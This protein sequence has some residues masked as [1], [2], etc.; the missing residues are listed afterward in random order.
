MSHRTL[1]TLCLIVTFALTAACG[2]SER[3]AS[4]TGYDGPTQIEGE[5]PDRGG[6]SGFASALAQLM[7]T[8][9]RND[10]SVHTL[11][12]ECAFE[13][14]G[15]NSV[16]QCLEDNIDELVFED[17]LTECFAQAMTDLPTPPASLQRV[18]NDALVASNTFDTC[19]AAIDTSSCPDDLETIGAAIETCEA[20]RDTALED[21]EPAEGDQDWIDQ[22]EQAVEEAGCFSFGPGDGG[23]PTP[24]STGGDVTPDGDL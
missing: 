10:N 23:N 1:A 9:A 7:G 15:Y 4:A 2:S 19:I 3:R 11:A 16:E 18:I 13:A 22:F 21:F 17:A 14:E 8:E 20:D 12:C 6:A 24:P 5:D